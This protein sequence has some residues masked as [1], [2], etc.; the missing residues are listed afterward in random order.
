MYVVNNLV[1]AS[2]LQW[3][4]ISYQYGVTSLRLLQHLKKSHILN[5]FFKCVKTG[6]KFTNFDSL[7]KKDKRVE[8]SI[9]MHFEK[10][11]QG[12]V[13]VLGTF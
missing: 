5:P 10:N 8:W 3:L 1:Y 6:S 11:V 12:T 13:E 7:K 4:V 9:L 2:G